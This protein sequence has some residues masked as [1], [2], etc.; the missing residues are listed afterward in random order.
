MVV[1][2]TR[3]EAIKMAP[4]IKELTQ[5]AGVHPILVSTS[6]HREMLQQVLDLFDIQPHHDLQIMAANQSLLHIVE[7]AMSGF[8]H[9]V[10]QE[11]PDMM[12]VQGDTTTAYAGA[13]AGFY[14]HIPVGH[15]EAGLR[16]FNIH[17]PFPEE[18]NRR[19]ISLLAEFHFAPTENNRQ[20]LLQEG[21][22][23][24]QIRVTGNT[25]IDALHFVLKNRPPSSLA[26]SYK[27]QGRRLILV[28]AHRRENFGEPLRKIC[29]ALLEIVNR[30]PDVE[31]VYPVHLNQNVQETVKALLSGQARIHLLNP[32]DYQDLCGLMQNSC[33]VLTDSGGIQEEA[34][35]LAKPVV[36][37]RTET[38][39][40]EAV[41]AG[42]VAVV[43]YETAAIVDKT[44]QLLTD[45]SA[46]E[47]MARAVNPYGDGRAAQRIVDFILNN[48]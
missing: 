7:K 5:R 2:G 46:Y 9:L 14:S 19:M 18:A 13:L 24:K 40:P 8:S 16:T 15:V 29:R 34:P 11:R 33:L 17:S 42:T 23:D 41:Q 37:L 12:L 44:T 45:V 25:V 39:R 22:A 48:L 26:D 1:F 10:Q 20:S 21:V 36:V 4:V 32:L 35:A 30:F 31:L 28:T 43:G 6:Q 47:R 27:K 3:P 38:E